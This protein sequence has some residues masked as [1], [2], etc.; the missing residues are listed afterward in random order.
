MGEHVGWGEVD[1]PHPA[2]CLRCGK[3]ATVLML[4]QTTVTLISL[5]NPGQAP[6]VSGSATAQ[7]LCATCVAPD[8][9]AHSA[10]VREV[11]EGHASAAVLRMSTR[12][13]E[14]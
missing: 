4:R 10:E 7:A 6:E 5:T 11:L 9:F 8:A 2:R 3:V 1:A 13:E 12:R 14:S